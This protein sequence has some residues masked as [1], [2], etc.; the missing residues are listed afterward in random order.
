MSTLT[1]G[2]GMQYATI[3]KAVA[4]SHDGDV[5]DVQVGSYNND[6]L[7]INDSITIQA[8]GG[9]VTMQ[10]TVAPPN[11][12][13]IVIVG[14]ATHAPNVTINGI[15]LTGAKISPGQGN[16]GAGIRYQN[17]NLTLNND[18]ITAN[19][20]GLLA[21]PYVAHTGTIIVNNSTF[22]ANGAGDGQ[23][24]NVYVNNISQFTFE[25][26]VSIG[27]YVGHDI[28]SRADNTSILNSTIGDG[29]S[30]TASY[31]IDLPNGGNAIIQGNTIQQGAAS[32]NPVIISYGEEGGILPGS[33][34]TVSDN[35]IMNDLHA[36]IP[37]MVRNSTAV[38]ATIDGNEYYGLT[39]AQLASGPASL[40]NDISLAVE[41]K[42]DP[43]GGGPT[44]LWI[45]A[46]SSTTHT[47]YK[48]ATVLVTG[49]SDGVDAGLGG[50]SL[51]STGLNTTVATLAGTTSDISLQNTGYV[52]SAGNDEITTNT[53][54]VNVVASGHD[55]IFAGSGG[56]HLTDHAGSSS[57]VVG[58]AGNFA[59]S[60]SGGALDYTAGSGSAYIV[61][62]S[63]AMDITFGSG[64]TTLNLGTGP[65]DLVFVNGSGGGNDLI[66]GYNAARDTA[67]FQGFAGSAIAS[68]SSSGGS[69]HLTLTDGTHVTF[70]GV[71]SLLLA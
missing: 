48:H 71:P 45:S 56:L 52:L 42:L 27:A 2:P 37:T 53:G 8:V 3:A 29:T 60:G 54:S 17:G 26:S 49:N 63:G 23:S 4:A 18:I 15:K 35:T 14:D 61:A 9:L 62:G 43:T 50:V 46:N 34:L 51:T 32:Q 55:T 41:P 10:A 7:Q 30:G 25:D 59:Y 1:V 68:Q 67:T 40:S 47:G 19:Q 36:H 22:T 39:A 58:G 38:V 24:H 44:S 5:I 65:G 28:K 21:T 31:E 70:Q 66:N 33:T 6:W 64:A 57:S 16:N 20:D 11:N 69:T 13:G 12:K